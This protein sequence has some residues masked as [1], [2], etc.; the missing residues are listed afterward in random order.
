MEFLPDASTRING[1]SRLLLQSGIIRITARK[2]SSLKRR[3]GAAG[4]LTFSFNRRANRPK[5]NLNLLQHHGVDSTARL[6]SS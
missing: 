1:N 4:V 3:L 2:R 5:P 6:A